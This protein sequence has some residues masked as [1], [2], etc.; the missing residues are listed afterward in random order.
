[1]FGESVRRGAKMYRQGKMY[2][3]AKSY[4]SCGYTRWGKDDSRKV[5]LRGNE[6]RECGL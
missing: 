1:M 5:V 2:G 4:G 3:C 6:C